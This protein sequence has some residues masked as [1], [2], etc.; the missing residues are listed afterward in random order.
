MDAS[1]IASATPTAPGLAD[2]PAR[3]STG[4]AN[5]SSFRET[6]ANG[7]SGPIGRATVATITQTWRRTPLAL[8]AALVGGL[9]FVWIQTLT[10]T[11]NIAEFVGAQIV[12]TGDYDAAFAS[13]IGWTVHLAIAV[14]YAIG[15]TALLALPIWP[16]RTAASVISKMAAAI[17]VGFIG[18]WVANPAISITVSMLGGAGWPE[19][20]YPVN[21]AFGVPLLNHLLFFA[22][23]LALVEGVPTLWHRFQSWNPVTFAAETH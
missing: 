17:A 16:R 19:T 22:L 3:P 2:H 6:L 18:T 14:Q 21:T 13:I 1:S 12:Q 23:T 10:G 7:L 5:A 20:L 8:M 15:F 11:K 9:G 4:S